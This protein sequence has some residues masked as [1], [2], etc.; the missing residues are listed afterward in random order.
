MPTTS[1][2]KMISGVRDD[3]ID[4]CMAQAGHADWVPAPDL[5]AVGGKTLTDW[6]YGIHDAT[7]AAERGY[8]PAAAEQQAYDE[9]MSEG[10]VDESGADDSALR[11]CVSE[12]DG[13][14][15]V[16]EAPL[17]AQQI[18][19][20]S[21][22]ASA[23]DPA[24]VDVF[25]KWASCMKEKGFTYTKPM[26]ANDDPQFTNPDQVTKLEID[27]AMADI[28]C[29]D[30][31]DVAKTWF[32]AEVTLQQAAIKEHQSELDGAKAEIASVVAKASEVAR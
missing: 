4:A 20:E 21:F 23:K 8:H 26:E 13:D 17:V 30:R 28:E 2:A 25:A 11:S 10:A 22:R 24:V 5:P 31:F 14:A 18:N 19:G 7:L 9:A 6:R 15:P 32:D 1:Q 12:A 16:A 3:L 29:R 27:T